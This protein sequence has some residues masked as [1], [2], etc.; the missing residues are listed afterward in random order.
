M[1]PRSKLFLP[2]E[3]S[4]IVLVLLMLL[5]RKSQ[6]KVSLAPPLVAMHLQDALQPT[7]RQ[8]DLIM[9]A[10]VV[11]DCQYFHS[12]GVLLLSGD[13]SRA[14]PPQIYTHLHGYIHTYIYV[15]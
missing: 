3:K 5:T 4:N 6:V 7:S 14:T 13:G 1:Q 12:G 8:L 2:S 10:S 9:F 11:I 15:V